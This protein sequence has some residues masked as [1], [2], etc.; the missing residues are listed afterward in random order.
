[1]FRR[2]GITSLSVGPRHGKGI[3][4][5]AIVH[6]LCSQFNDATDVKSATSEPDPAL[7]FQPHVADMVVSTWLGSRLYIYVLPTQPRLRD[8]KAIL[9]ENSRNSIGT[10]FVLN[11]AILPEHEATS[12]VGDWLEGLLNLGDQWVYAYSVTEEGLSLTQV[13]FNPTTVEHE[14]FCWYLDD[15]KIENVSVRKREIGGN[16]RGT[17]SVGDIASPSYRRR[18][19]YERVNQRYHYKT[20]K[21]EQIPH[22][23]KPG[24]TNGSVDKLMQYYKMIGVGRN[25]SEAEIKTAFRKRALQVHPDVS[26]LPRSEAEK[27]IKA[28]NEAYEFIKDYH[29]WN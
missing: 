28:L 24:L 29:G 3:H 14:Y 27:H 11:L 9:K 5:N 7:I 25:A 23:R 15:F 20:K 4:V 6:W 10:L 19:N 1:M 18:V 2:V 13:N 8:I 22:Q 12:R 26:A 16:I 21:T 17:Y